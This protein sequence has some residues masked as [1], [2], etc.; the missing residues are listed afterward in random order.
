M[1]AVECNLVPG[2]FLFTFSSLPR[3]VNAVHLVLLQM[4]TIGALIDMWILCVPWHS[5]LNLS[6]SMFIECQVLMKL[7]TESEHFM[8]LSS[9]FLD[10]CLTDTWVMQTR[11]GGKNT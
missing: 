10:V 7:P 9:S 8:L 6:E 4:V 3:L 2:V 11:S 5:T 1:V